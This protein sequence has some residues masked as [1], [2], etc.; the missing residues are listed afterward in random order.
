MYVFF[1]GMDNQEIF[2]KQFM[3]LLTNPLLAKNW[4]EHFDIKSGYVLPVKS[5]R[6]NI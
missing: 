4:N 6:Q 3:F 1:E 2:L 5:S